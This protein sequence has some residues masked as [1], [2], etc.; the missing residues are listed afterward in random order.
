[1]LDLPVAVASHLECQGGAAAIAKRSERAQRLA[2]LYGKF[3]VDG[4]SENLQATHT[5]ASRTGGLGGALLQRRKPPDKPMP[6]VGL[7]PG[8]GA[9]PAWRLLAALRLPAAQLQEGEAGAVLRDGLGHAI[10]AL[11]HTHELRVV[12]PKQLGLIA[13]KRPVGDP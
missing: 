7:V 13:A 4:C 5:L 8:H 6:G 12:K 3:D 10:A 11:H 2:S 9:E 1:V